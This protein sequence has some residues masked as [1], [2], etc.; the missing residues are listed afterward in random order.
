MKELF[1]IYINKIGTNFKGEHIFEFLFSDRTD[2]DWDESWYES[3]VVTDKNDLTP[4]PNYI[5]LVGNLKTEELDLELVQN[6]G[7]F[8]IYNAIEGI[9][10]LG[11]EI[12]EDSDEDYPEER[13]V[14]K[15][16]ESKE[17]IENKLYSMDLVLNYNETKVKN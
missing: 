16:G 6:S 11:W 2:W 15:F 10:A 7:V 12:L 17:S 14:F 5:K 4:E 1:L 13:I 8:Q 3:S 9:I